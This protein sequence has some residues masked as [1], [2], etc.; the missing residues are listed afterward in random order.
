[1]KRSQKS[2][3]PKDRFD[4]ILNAV[5]NLDRKTGLKFDSL[6][7]QVSLVAEQVAHNTGKIS[8]IKKTLENHGD[9]LD[10]IQQDVEIIKYDLKEK[11]ERIEVISLSR[12]VTTL[13]K[14]MSNRR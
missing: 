12:R 14:K 11:P 7:H 13:E 9:K 4:E 2:K 3:K 6:H 1:M 10:N 8:E 5:S